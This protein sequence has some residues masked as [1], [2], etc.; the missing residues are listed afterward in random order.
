VSTSAL[1]KDRSDELLSIIDNIDP[2]DKKLMRIKTS[3]NYNRTA[4]ELREEI[5]FLPHLQDDAYV[6]LQDLVRSLHE[7]EGI[8]DSEDF[9]REDETMK[10]KCRALLSVTELFT[11]RRVYENCV[12]ESRTGISLRDPALISLIISNTDRIGLITGYLRDRLDAG[13]KIVDVSLLEELLDSTAPAI[14]NGVL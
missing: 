14:G 13:V 7:Y 1:P 8:L 6:F 4:N 5:C 3:V 2:A 10:G 12:S 11:Q 9:S